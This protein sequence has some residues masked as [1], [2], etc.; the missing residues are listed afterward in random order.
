MNDQPSPGKKSFKEKK[1]ISVFQ[2]ANRSA[3]T[4]IGCKNKKKSPVCYTDGVGGNAALC[5]LCNAHLF[6]PSTGLFI[7]GEPSDVRAP[8]VHGHPELLENEAPVASIPL[9]SSHLSI[10]AIDTILQ[11]LLSVIAVI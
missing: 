11:G 8:Q 10:P 3:N 5:P 9:S 7:Q 1:K 4:T 6:L 2:F